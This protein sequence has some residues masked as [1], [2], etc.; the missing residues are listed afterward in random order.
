MFIDFV[1]ALLMET[2]CFCYD[3]RSSADTTSQLRPK[4]TLS[5]ASRYAVYVA[6]FMNFWKDH[7]LWPWP[8]NTQ[9]YKHSLSLNLSFWQIKMV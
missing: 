3:N 2:F 4:N 6:A 9:Y 8:Q 1:A 5:K 7:H